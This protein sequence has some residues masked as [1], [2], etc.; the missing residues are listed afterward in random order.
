MKCLIRKLLLSL[1]I[2]IGTQSYAQYSKKQIDSLLDNV[3]HIDN[4]DQG[5]KI[6][7]NAYHASKAINYQEGMVRALLSRAVKYA[8][9]RHYDKAFKYAVEAESAAT[10]LNNPRYLALLSALKGMSYTNLGF[11]EEG[12]E[13]L[14][15]AIP[16][17]KTIADVDQRHYRLANIYAALSENTGLSGGDLKTKM[18]Y[19]K[20]SY[21][22]YGGIIKKSNFSN[23]MAL[24][25][26]N[27]GYNFFL[28]KQY[29][30]AKFY[31]N[32]AV[33]LGD[34]Y[35]EDIAKANAFKV[36]GDLYFQEKKYSKSEINYKK[37]ITIFTELKISIPL[38]NAYLGLSK[39]YIALNEK[40]KTQQYLER[41]IELIDSLA[42]VE[43]DAVKTR[44][45]YIVK[46]KE[47]QL[48]ENRSKNLRTIL[49]IGFL[50]IIAVCAI[51]FFRYRFKKKLQLSTEKVDELI[52]RIEL[53]DDN[54]RPVSKTE[55]L[56]EIVQMGVNND[57]AFIAKYNEFDPEFSKKL[58]NIAPNLVAA[59]IEFCILLKLNFNTKEIARYSKVSVRTVEGRKYRIRKKLGIPSNHHINIWMSHL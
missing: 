2:L 3:N 34:E 54:H 59:E 22:E 12:K 6:A 8:N 39:V 53:N 13:T 16:I 4:L 30:S 14:L 25:T 42:K 11:Y 15:S 18:I 37:A 40:V 38:K 46:Y 48:V 43:K 9:I 19:S 7:V 36:L 33:I 57:P 52:K 55:E 32:K 50:L 58:F 1:L 26:Y 47:Q 35:Q 17:A 5:V 23:V 10:K 20:K 28:V 49:I 41:S 24:P 29:D 45:D 51:F 27:V 44:L 21:F 31:L 56:K